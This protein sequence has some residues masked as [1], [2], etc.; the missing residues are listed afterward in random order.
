MLVWQA[1][2]H[3]TA[4]CWLHGRCGMP[5]WQAPAPNW[6]GNPKSLYQLKSAREFEELP[7]HEVQKKQ[8]SGVQRGASKALGSEGRSCHVDQRMR[9]SK[10]ERFCLSPWTIPSCSN[11]PKRT[12]LRLHSATSCFHPSTM[13]FLS[14]HRELPHRCSDR[15]SSSFSSCR[16]PASLVAPSASTF[17]QQAWRPSWPFSH[18]AHPESIPLTASF[19]ARTTPTTRPL[20]TQTYPCLGQSPLPRASFPM[21]AR[22]HRCSPRRGSFLLAFGQRSTSAA[23]HFRSC[24]P[25]RMHTNHCLP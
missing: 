11:P 2:A 16:I 22:W 21:S 19:A 15:S 25:E 13:L 20:M 7:I 18:W 1:P 10:V 23:Q 5:A 9:E 24:Y 17:L 14:C 12:N 4:G 3:L 6:Q 8:E